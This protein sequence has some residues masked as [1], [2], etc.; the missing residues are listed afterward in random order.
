MTS[1]VVKKSEQM[2]LSNALTM[3]LL[4]TCPLLLIY[5]IFVLIPA[6][7]A[8]IDSAM[9]HLL[10]SIDKPNDDDDKIYSF[11]SRRRPILV[12]KVSLIL[13][14]HLTFKYLI[15]TI[16]LDHI[17]RKHFI[18]NKITFLEWI[19]TKLFILSVYYLHDQSQNYSIESIF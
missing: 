10:L 1:S 9:H 8:G 4:S 6:N 15:K 2:Y 7:N 19:I 3:Y 11:L 12:E 14:L 16:I 17:N 5:V 13:Y 18:G